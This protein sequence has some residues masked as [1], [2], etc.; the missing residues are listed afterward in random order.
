MLHS[1]LYWMTMLQ[2][3]NL[4]KKLPSSGC[5]CRFAS[6]FLCPLFDENCKVR[7][8][9]AVDSEHQKNQMNDDWRLFQLEKATCNQRHPF[10]KFETGQWFYWASFKTATQGFSV[11]QILTEWMLDESVAA[12]LALQWSEAWRLVNAISRKL[13]I[14]ASHSNIYLRTSVHFSSFWARFSGS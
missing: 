6:F 9:N 14:G 7:E 1:Q 5:G 4:T 3:P 2:M 11:D 12:F 10:S 13:Y 8:L